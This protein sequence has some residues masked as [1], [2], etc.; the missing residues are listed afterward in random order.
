LEVAGRAVGAAL[1]VVVL[2]VFV[3]VLVVFVL[4]E[5]H[6]VQKPA[7]ASSAKRAKVLRMFFLLS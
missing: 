5:E 6:P 7:T 1:F 3:V 4:S 2:L